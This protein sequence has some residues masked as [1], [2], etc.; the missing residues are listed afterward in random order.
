[1]SKEMKSKIDYDKII[2]KIIIKTK[3]FLEVPSIIEHEK[4]FIDYLEK[5]LKNLDLNTENKKNKYLVAK[6]KKNSNYI[7]SAHID[8]HGFYKGDKSN[9]S[10][11]AF[12]FLKKNNLKLPHEVRKIGEDSIIAK[13]K[14]KVDDK[15]LNIKEYRDFVLL[16]DEEHTNVK[17]SKPFSLDFFEKVGLR[18][19]KD[20]IRGYNQEN[21]EIGEW[22]KIQMYYPSVNSKT[23]SFNILDEDKIKIKKFSTFQLNSTCNTF[24]NF[25]SGQID[26]IISTATIITLIE[27]KLISGTF[28]FTTLEEV[29]QSYKQV[30]EYYNNYSNKLKNKQLIILDTSPYDS[31]ENKKEGFLTLRYGDENGGF[32][33]SL[34]EKIKLLVESYDIPYDFK[35]SFMGKTELGRISTKT[36]G[37]INGTTIQLPT[38]NYHTSHETCELKGIENYAKILVKLLEEN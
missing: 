10:Y 23:V 34:V 28:I 1:M 27:E 32:N 5:Q 18:Y 2:N 29:G 11:A 30:V 17:F 9:I 14:D 7:F 24:N 26:N 6:T 15:L 16:S 12:E 35:P 13:I 19:V 8:R 20:Y 21:E 37:K 38:L 22:I 31:F 25:F 3:E 33:S 4:L 36:K